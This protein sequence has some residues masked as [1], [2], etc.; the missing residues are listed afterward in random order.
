MLYHRLGLS[1]AKLQRGLIRRRS[2]AQYAVV[3][4]ELLEDRFLLSGNPSGGI[5]GVSTKPD[6]SAAALV[7]NRPDPPGPLPP[8]IQRVTASNSETPTGNANA[9]AGAREASGSTIDGGSQD[10]GMPDTVLCDGVV[11]GAGFAKWTWTTTSS[12]LPTVCFAASAQNASASLPSPLPPGVPAGGIFNQ[13]A[14]RSS[15]ANISV[16]SLDPVAVDLAPPGSV[17]A[18]SLGFAAVVARCQPT[19]V[20]AQPAATGFGLSFVNSVVGPSSDS[21]LRPVATAT[22]TRPRGQRAELPDVTTFVP[23]D[24][25]NGPS[26]DF[27]GR[28]GPQRV[29]GSTTDLSAETQHLGA[30]VTLPAAQRSVVRRESDSSQNESAERWIPANLVIYSAASMMVGVSAPG[31]TPLARRSKGARTPD[32]ERA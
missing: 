21:N 15:T 23:L 11:S 6:S 14:A 29:S 10:A 18:G 2:S 13:A 25:A 30:I 7:D 24:V 4:L 8:G 17:A 1:L 12:Q 27:V 22:I 28:A 5:V 3:P 31:M 32:V 26:A 16:L 9:D 20:S 19:S